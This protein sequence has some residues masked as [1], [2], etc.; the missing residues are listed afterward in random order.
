[1]QLEL[2]RISLTARAQGDFDDLKGKNGSIPTREEC[3]R[4]AFSKMIQFSVRSKAYYYTPVPDFEEKI[5]IF[6]RIGRQLQVQESLPPEEELTEIVRPQW[7]SS[8]IIIDPTHHDD[9]QQIAIESKS[10]V[11]NCNTI[12]KAIAEHINRNAFIPYIIE[13]GPIIDT[14]TFWDFEKENRG[15][16]T[17]ITVTAPVPNMFNHSGNIDN[18]MKEYRDKERASTVTHS[19]ANPDGLNVETERV[20]EGVE[21]AAKTGGSI[22]ATALGKKTYNSDNKSK[23]VHSTNESEINSIKSQA[24]KALIKILEME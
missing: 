15:R 12:L 8:K 10:D 14:R 2:F 24:I 4:H 7:Q 17:K 1:M 18:D 20:R 13:I 5:G 21:Y 16:I 11:G 3:I 23:R 6:G 22:R 9:G 19:L